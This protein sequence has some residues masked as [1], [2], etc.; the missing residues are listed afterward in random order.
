[1]FLSDT[2]N[3][4]VVFVVIVVVLVCN[5]SPRTSYTLRKKIHIA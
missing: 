4:A 2:L 1:M 3:C 5:T